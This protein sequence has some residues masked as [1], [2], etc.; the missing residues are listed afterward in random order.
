[1][2]SRPQS[3]R[4]PNVERDEPEVQH[5]VERLAMV[6]TEMGFQRMAARVFATLMSTDSGQLTAAELAERL[7]VSPAAV[8]GAVRFLDQL[9]L[10]AKRREPG[11]RRDHY[12]LVD[13]LWYSTFLKRDRMMIMWRD[14]T[15]EGMSVL[16][17]ETPAGRRL[18]E[19]CSFLDFMIRELPAMFE[20]W[21][22]QRQEE[23]RKAG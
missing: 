21:H 7:S 20:R 5:Y 22:Q 8:S 6:L 19:M 15:V 1:M 11:G 18:G 16:G 17:E 13:D 12:C 10:V 3:Q 23:Q 14:A 9:G 4:D 2:S